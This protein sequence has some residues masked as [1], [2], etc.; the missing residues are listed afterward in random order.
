MGMEFAEAP[1]MEAMRDEKR[2]EEEAKKEKVLTEDDCWE[3]LTFMQKF[4]PTE[5]DDGL[6]M[7]CKNTLTGRHRMKKKVGLQQN[8]PHNNTPIYGVWDWDGDAYEA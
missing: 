3:Y 8:D 2:R 1:D 4:S 5:E 7:I 6:R